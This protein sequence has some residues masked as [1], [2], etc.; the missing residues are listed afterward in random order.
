MVLETEKRLTL[1]EVLVVDLDVHAHETPEGLLP[2][3]DPPWR[4]ALAN[5]TR[6]P[7][8]YLDRPGFAVTT[9]PPLLGPPIPRKQRDEVVLTAAQMRQELDALS[10]DVGIIFPDHFLKIGALPR[11][12]YAAALARAYHRWLKEE[13]LSQ[14]NDLYAVLIAIPQDPEEAAREIARWAGDDRFVG[15]FLPTCQTYPLWGHRRYDPIFAAAQRFDLPVVFHAVLGLA[16]GFPYNTEGFATYIPR[17]TI[18][19]VFAMMANLLSLLESGVPV[20]YPALRLCFAE[21]GLSWVPFLRLR[22]DKEYNENRWMWPHFDDRPSRWIRRFY[23]ATQPVE[24]PENRQD[25]VDL[26]RLYDGEDTTLFASDWPHHDF[27][28]PRA[29]FDLPLSERAKRKIM[30]ANALQFMPKI[31][32]PTKYQGLYRQ[33]ETL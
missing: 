33:G 18:S 31:R 27:D 11:A 24:E 5:L 32:V 30:G 10:I 1:D 20:R 4:E 26:I 23:F 3:C 14:D 16:T 29:V 9:S 13:W 25:L 22:L 7:A 12:D 19:H 28:H 2:Y 21:S 6:I 8:R 17:H 15:V